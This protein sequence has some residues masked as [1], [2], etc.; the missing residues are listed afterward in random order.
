MI[1]IYMEQINNS[2]S[3]LSPEFN[4]LFSEKLYGAGTCGQ[5]HSYAFATPLVD[6]TFALNPHPIDPFSSQSY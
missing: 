1:D 4:F 2:N 6:H 3:V 5:Y